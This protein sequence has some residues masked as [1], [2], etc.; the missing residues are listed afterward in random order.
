ME[1]ARLK[2]QTGSAM[3]SSQLPSPELLDHQNIMWSFAG[4][5]RKPR[6]HWPRVSP[7]QAGIGVVTQTS[8]SDQRKESP[9]QSK[10][11]RLRGG[12][13]SDAKKNLVRGQICV[14]VTP[15]RDRE[16][17]ELRKSKVAGPRTF[18]LKWAGL[19]KHF[20]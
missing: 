2:S 19:P 8:G 7:P 6:T 1:W 12:S 9:D 13:G 20:H 11:K 4:E 17:Q 15:S 14:K 18:T 3:A 10:V 16:T 5:A